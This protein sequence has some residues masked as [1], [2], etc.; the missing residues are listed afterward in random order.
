M[1]LSSAK[2]VISSKQSQHFE[3]V[4]IGSGFSGL[5]TAIR[6]QKKKFNDYVL[7]DRNADIGG[8]WRDNSYPGAE[9][10]IPTGL[11]S[12]SFLPYKFTKKYLPQS[13]LLEYTNYIIGIFNIR[14]KTQTNRS[15]K[16]LTYNE[17][18]SLW[19]V[20]VESGEKYSARFIIDTSGVLANPHTP[21]LK[22]QNPFK[23]LNFIQDNGIMMFLML[24]NESE[25]LV[26]DVQQHR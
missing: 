25:L 8:T 11:Y 19:H 16:T 4:I 13:E 24:E 2:D 22:V 3:T 26:R 10:D 18:T 15:V 23:E 21:D 12:F 20:E 14:E 6:L 17:E 1:Q 5:L 7:L 9:V